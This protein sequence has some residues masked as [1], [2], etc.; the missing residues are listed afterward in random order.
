MEQQSKVSLENHPL[1]VDLKTA[2]AKNAAALKTM[3]LEQ[4]DKP[5]DTHG[6]GFSV[7]RLV[8]GHT[9]EEKHTAPSQHRHTAD[10]QNLADKG[11]F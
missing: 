9:A 6:I 5:A 10:K 7:A 3:A 8:T 4:S 1:I 11:F 2:R